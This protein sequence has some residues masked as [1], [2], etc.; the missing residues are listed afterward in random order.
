MDKFDILKKY[1][2]HE[3]AI[4]EYEIKTKNHCGAVDLVTK[5]EIYANYIDKKWVEIRDYLENLKKST[6]CLKPSEMLND[7]ELKHTICYFWN[8]GHINIREY[9]SLY[10]NKVRSC[11]ES[12]HELSNAAEGFREAVEQDKI[13]RII[14]YY[15]V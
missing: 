3:K 14:N 9:C 1:D 8:V 6:K 5:F 11:E 4:K 13:I 12:I 7:E 15:W 10:N 2:L